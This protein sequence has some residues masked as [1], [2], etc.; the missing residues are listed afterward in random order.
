LN[1]DREF[2]GK[3]VKIVR[4]INWIRRLAQKT[5]ASN[6]DLAEECREIQLGQFVQTAEHKNLQ[7]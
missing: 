1:R 6:K 2:F 5:D 4:E 7:K 3:E